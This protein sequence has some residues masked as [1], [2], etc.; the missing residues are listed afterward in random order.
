MISTSKSKRAGRKSTGTQSHPNKTS[1]VANPGELWR[2]VA[3]SKANLTSR[4]QQEGEQCCSEMGWHRAINETSS[5]VLQELVGA[6]HQHALISPVATL[7]GL[8]V[9]KVLS[10]VWKKLNP[11]FRSPAAAQDHLLHLEGTE[12]VSEHIHRSAFFALELQ[13]SAGHRGAVL[14]PLVS[15]P[16]AGVT[17]ALGSADDLLFI[18]S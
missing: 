4:S 11:S 16:H 8:Q 17:Q 13:S 3:V 10:T 7:T 9:N 2:V 1:G 12:Q 6:L 18:F 14:P 5:P 15:H